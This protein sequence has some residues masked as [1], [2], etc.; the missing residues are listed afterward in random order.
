MTL[1]KVLTTMALMGVALTGIE[2][3]AQ[4]P[5]VWVG[6]WQCLR[7]RDTKVDAEAI[8]QQNGLNPSVCVRKAAGAFVG[9]LGK[10]RPIVNRPDAALAPD[11]GGS[12]PPRRL[13][14]CPTSRQR[15]HFYV[16]HP[17]RAR[18]H[19]PV[20][21]VRYTVGIHVQTAG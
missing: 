2:A 6:G 1:G 19:I 5:T 14:A 13:P 21:G 17:F 18:A 9:Q 20:P 11:G 12:Q 3:A 7:V 8:H 16:V 4:V 15:F 10:L